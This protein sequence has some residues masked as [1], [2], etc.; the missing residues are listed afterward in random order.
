MSVTTMND[1]LK[2]M[3]KRESHSLTEQQALEQ[4]SVLTLSTQLGKL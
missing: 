4:R 2:K 3:K 1:D